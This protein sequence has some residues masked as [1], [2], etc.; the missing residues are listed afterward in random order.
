MSN[1]EFDRYVK[2]RYKD[3]VNWYSRKADK[4]KMYYLLLQGTVIV[5]AAIT[6]VII[7]LG[8]QV[9]SWIGV[10]AS[11][12]VAIGTA[13][14]KAFKYQENWNN[15]RA[16]CETLQREI[17]CYTAEIGEYG[18]SQDPQQLFVSRVESLISSENTVWL[19]TQKPKEG[20][21]ETQPPTVG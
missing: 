8:E 18:G 13:L 10:L 3:Q 1:E 19:S 6:P 5:L 21:Q 14:L 2:E 16:T 11:S 12:L 20:T 4:N 9:A 17:H 7:A 15:Y